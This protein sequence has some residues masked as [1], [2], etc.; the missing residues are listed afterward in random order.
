MKASEAQYLVKFGIRDRLIENVYESIKQLARHGISFY[1]TV[2]SDNEVEYIDEIEKHFTDL[3]YKVEIT[4]VENEQDKQ[5]GKEEIRIHKGITF[6][7]SE[8]NE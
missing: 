3:G 5:R 6:D 4:D 8:T 2:L 1:G 7:W